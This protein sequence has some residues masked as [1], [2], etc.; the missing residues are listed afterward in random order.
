VRVLSNHTIPWRLSSLVDRR[1]R[2]QS[3][4]TTQLA[5]LI[6]FLARHH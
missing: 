1:S 4:W 5:L 2:H 3:G 6:A